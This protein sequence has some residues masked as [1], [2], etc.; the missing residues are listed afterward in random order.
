MQHGWGMSM[1]LW[2]LIGLVIFLVVIFLILRTG[3]ETRSTN[4]ARE[5]LNERYARGEI[6]KEEYEEIKRGLIDKDSMYQN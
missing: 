1:G 4:K 2:W 3:P 5:V 6:K